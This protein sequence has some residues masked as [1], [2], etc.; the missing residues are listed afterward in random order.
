MN[1]KLSKD[2]LNKYHNP[3]SDNTEAGILLDEDRYIKKVFE[4]NPRLGCEIL[5]SRYFSLL[6]SHATRFVYSREVAEDIVSEIFCHLWKE[7]IFNQIVGSYRGYLFKAVRYR[8]YNYV[9]WEMSRK[10][11]KDVFDLDIE[12]LEMNPDEVLQ[13]DELTQKIENTI[14]EMPPQCR[15][16]FLLSRFENK[17]YKEIASELN[18]SVKAV[19]AHVSKALNILRKALKE[20]IA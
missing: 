12:L 19:E 14:N 2:E 7:Q 18:I 4:Q 1:Y 20:E 9:R 17:K 10:S 8:A 5:F 15:N 11:D 13:F 3:E 16:V 6:C